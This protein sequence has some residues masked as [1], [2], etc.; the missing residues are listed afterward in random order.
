[1]VKTGPSWIRPWASEVW[2]VGYEVNQAVGK[3][4]LVECKK[5]IHD[6]SKTKVSVYFTVEANKPESEWR[7]F[8]CVLYFHSSVACANIAAQS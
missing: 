1:M 5:T 2:L 4:Q 7:H 6:A 8:T 3:I